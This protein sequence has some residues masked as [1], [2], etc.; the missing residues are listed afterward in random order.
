MENVK[1]ILILSKKVRRLK[2]E[3]KEMTEFK[4]YLRHELLLRDGVI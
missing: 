1:K 3:L 2:R 4:D